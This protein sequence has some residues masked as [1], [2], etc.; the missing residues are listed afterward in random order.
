[1]F[2][3]KQLKVLS[4]NRT[5]KLLLVGSVRSGKSH[6]NYYKFLMKLQEK[7]SGK[8][9]GDVAI[10]GVTENTVLRNVLNPMQDIFGTQ[11]VKFSLGKHEAN[12]FGVR[13]Y[14]IGADDEAAES[15]IK[16]MTLSIGMIDE[17]TEL[18]ESATNQIM[19]RLSLPHSFL[20]ASTNPD[21]PYHYVKQKLVNRAKYVNFQ[22]NPLVPYD[23]A[24]DFEIVNFQLEDN[25]TLTT[26]YKEGLKKLYTGFWYRRY[27]LGEWCLAE[28]RVYDVFNSD[29]HTFTEYS[30]TYDEYWISG[31]FGT[32]VPTVFLLW[33]RKDG[34]SYILKELYYKPPIDREGKDEDALCEDLIAMLEEVPFNMGSI[35]NLP[36][37]FDPAASTMIRK[38]NQYGFKL[39]K[40][41]NHDVLDGLRYV[42]S[43]FANKKLFV[44]ST[45]YGLLNEIVD[46]SWNVKKQ[47]QGKEEPI[48]R[49]DHACDAM[50]YG[51]YTQW[52]GKISKMV[53][54]GAQLR[55]VR[56]L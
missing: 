29:M 22:I 7:V 31:D 16:G 48:K 35:Y 6:V 19:A 50:R 28:G 42:H 34:V 23:Q 15:K 17:L 26:E 5:S 1:M 25:P 37:Y 44:H 30:E 43:A 10:F 46:Y 13:I 3:R 20:L 55:A 49:N 39:V 33:G 53:V 14:I 21:S 9:P 27:I 40:K 51:Y 36:I 11:A 32:S 54:P 2:S 52:K 18:P 41:A 12:I 38:L 47:E 56:G 8:L 45:C 4:L 24:I